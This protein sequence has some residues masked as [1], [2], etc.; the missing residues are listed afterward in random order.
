MYAYEGA[1]S[2]AE[3]QAGVM[4]ITV[5]LILSMV[6]RKRTYSSLFLRRNREEGFGQ[7]PYNKK[8]K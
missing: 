4:G 2:N 1:F 3:V 6:R 8:V 7:T 5:A